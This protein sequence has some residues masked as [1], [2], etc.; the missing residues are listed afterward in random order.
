MSTNTTVT[1]PTVVQVNTKHSLSQV[2]RQKSAQKIMHPCAAVT[3]M[4]LCVP[5]EEL[6][7]KKKKGLSQ[8]EPDQSPAVC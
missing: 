6:R 3:P 4:L 7:R 8:P 5:S 2:S 1:T